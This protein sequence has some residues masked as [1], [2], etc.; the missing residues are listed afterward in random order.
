MYAN[1]QTIHSLYWN[2]IC[3]VC[4]VYINP[5]HEEHIPCINRRLTSFKKFSGI[6]RDHSQS[7]HTFMWQNFFKHIDIDPANAHILNGNAS[8][9]EEECQSYEEK[10]KEAGGIELFMGGELIIQL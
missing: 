5:S 10:I 2:V 4:D 3:I 6:P 7:Y 9:L 8:S 1:L